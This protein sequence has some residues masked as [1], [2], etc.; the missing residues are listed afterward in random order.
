MIDKM[1]QARR[2]GTNGLARA[3]T[4]GAALGVLAHAGAALAQ[5]APA[6]NGQLE[7]I[8]VTATKT[9][10]T[11]LQKTA[12]AISAF[13]SNELERSRIATVKDLVQF[14]PNL[15]V[16]QNNVFAQI[17]IRGIGSN[18][19][20][21]GSDPSSTVQVD[22]VYIARPFSQFGSFLDVERVEVLR[23]P[24]GTLYGRNSVGG[25]INVISRA[26]TDTLSAKAEVV[27][28]NYGLFSEQAYVSGP[29]IADKL[30]F[31]LSESY[32]RH[33]PYRKNIVATGNDIDDQNQGSARAQLLWRVAD[34]VTATT[35]ADYASADFHPMGYAKLLKP[36]NAVTDTILGDY[37]KVA[38]S[39]RGTGVMRNSGLAEDISIDLPNG[40]KL[41]SLT[42][43]RQNV[44]KTFTDT[45]STNLNTTYS[46][47]SE[48]QRQFSEEL[49]LSGRVGILDYVTGLYY[50]REKVSTYSV[51]Q[52]LAA[53][54]YTGIFPVSH[55]EAKAA[56]AQGTFH[57][58][59]RLTGTL[60]MRYSEEEKIFN[61]NVGAYRQATNLPV[62]KAPTVYVG[63]GRYH[64]FTPKFGLDY[65][66]TDDIFGYVSATRGF[67]SGG[68][69]QTSTTVF[70]Q[71]GFA[72]EKLWAYEAGVKTTWLDRRLRLNLTA[73]HYDY[74]DLQVQN[75]ITPGV[76]DI[77][78]AATAKVDGL[79]FEAVARPTRA[80]TLNGNL[81]LLDA[82]YDK[83]PGA[84]GTGG[85]VIDASGNRL[86]AAPKLSG[87]L[88]AQYDWTLANSGVIS[89][90][91][92]GFWQAR[93]Y[94]VASNDPAQSQKGYGLVNAS[95]AYDLP[96]GRTQVSLWGKNL[97]DEEYVTATATISPVV[98]G[99][100]GEPRT[101]GVRL[102]WK[103]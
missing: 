87:N 88:S 28:G 27:G 18:N 29:I 94:F 75:F 60:G 72:P 40:M 19:V 14:T 36:L 41:K 71:N 74:K 48:R 78:N 56:Y 102:G 95:L 30:L 53:G 35:R 20:F 54:T 44:T 91:G 86:N 7:E 65:R 58:S 55:V 12:I 45:D 9:G 80:L 3:L 21:N 13:S 77:S 81:A 43:A 97:L 69:N 16:A 49:N 73:F 24:Q 31:S 84:S 85:V 2:R 99:R 25:T 76:T 10:A 82:K 33:D 70:A 101:I 68:F 4:A 57:F 90:R 62:S 22:G 96:D 32:S 98:S 89:L 103:M 15:A 59:D 50:F 5:T 51:I 52:Q 11:A 61:G 6:D 66:F 17:Y 37:G 83:Y 26:P 23:G 39:G 64:A 46:L 8:V 34:G 67:K 63:V 42:A 100:P 38:L 47:T 1:V 79:E 92:E 93:E